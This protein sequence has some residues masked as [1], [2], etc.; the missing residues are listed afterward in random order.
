ML[1][2]FLLGVKNFRENLRPGG[3]DVRFDILLSSSDLDSS[4]RMIKIIKRKDKYYKINKKIDNII[5]SF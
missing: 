5:F 1:E 3:S 2:D 4:N